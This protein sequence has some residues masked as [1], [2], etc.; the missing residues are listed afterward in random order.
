MAIEPATISALT[1][2]NNNADA[3]TTMKHSLSLK[4]TVSPSDIPICNIADGFELFT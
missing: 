1:G 3:F 2:G 4:D